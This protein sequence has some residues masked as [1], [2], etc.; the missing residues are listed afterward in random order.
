[1]VKLSKTNKAELKVI[2]SPLIENHHALMQTTA[3]LVDDMSTRDAAT[4]SADSVEEVFA[5][6]FLCVRG[7]VSC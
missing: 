2:M 5:S 3:D 7:F 6:L 1:M 4:P